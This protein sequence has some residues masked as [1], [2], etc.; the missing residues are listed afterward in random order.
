MSK[1]IICDIDGTLLEHHGDC[2]Q[3]VSRSPVLLDGTVEK[4]IEWDRQG[5]NIILITGRR[6]SMREKTVQQLQESGIF[7]DQ[8]IMGIGGGCRVLINDLKIG[9]P[10]PTA[11]AVNLKRNKGIKDVK[12]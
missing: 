2:Y 4:L 8:L 11:K 5:H 12:V 1:T 7:Y 3:Q 9:D 10:K 6:E